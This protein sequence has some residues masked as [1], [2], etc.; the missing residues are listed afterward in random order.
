MYNQ[1]LG[2]SIMKFA[3]TKEH[4][5]YFEKEGWI[6]FEQFFTPDQIKQLNHLIDL[7]IATRAAIPSQK[8]S[9]LI[10]ERLFME[11]RDL[12]RYQEE[13]KKMESQSR[14]GQVI[15]DLLDKKPL[16]LG[17][18]QL[19]PSPHQQIWYTSGES[20]HYNEFIK[21]IATLEEMSCI[22]GIICGILIALSEPLP[23]EDKTVQ[24]EEG[25]LEEGIDIFPKKRGN[26]IFFHPQRKINMK[27]IYSHPGQ[28]FYLIV[29][30]QS[31]ASYH[32]QPRDP[33]THH[34]K[35]LGY[36]FNDKLSDRLHPIVYR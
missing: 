30:T 28:R 17:Y 14:L 4:R 22:Q 36:I 31:N 23:I 34:L 35:Q 24:L 16:R 6:E 21:Q 1:F 29:Y 3:I 9:M 19:F 5:D 26:V 11:G 10:A 18:D 33:H 15:F 12:W 8:V 20:K 27:K 7:A 25:S 32:L 13:L 2:H